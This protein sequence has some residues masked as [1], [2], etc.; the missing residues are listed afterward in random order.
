MVPVWVAGID[1][2]ST[3]TKA[4]VMGGDGVAAHHVVPTGANVERAA[5]KA[6]DEVAER[7]AIRAADIVRVV[8]TG[9]GRGKI[10]F[11][12]EAVTEIGCHARGAKWLFPA[13][14]VV[15]DVGGQ[16]TKVIRLDGA[17][18][19]VDFRMNEKC[20][21]GT[22]RF[23]EVM[24]RALELD[25]ETFSRIGIGAV[26]RADI[27][28]TCTVFAETEVVSHVAAGTPV[29]EIVA[30]IHEAI[31]S[32]VYGLA[33]ALLSEEGDVVFT[34]GVAKNGGM[35]EALARKIGPRLRVPYD[36]QIVGAIGAAIS[37]WRALLKD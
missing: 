15:I 9:Y 12:H 11:A 24:A 17:G 6:L 29:E 16:D 4:V 22:G 21:A 5:K 1:S 25:L 18:K 37:A 35:V 8:A 19:V 27:S 33:K 26:R 13:T 23:L 2:G 34:G 28:S 30:G 7:A 32:R 36:P 3:T 10:S 20:A 31:A 14:R